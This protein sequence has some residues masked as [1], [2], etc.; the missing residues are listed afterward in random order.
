MAQSMARAAWSATVAAA[1]AQAMARDATVA[2]EAARAKAH[3][4]GARGMG[5]TNATVQA[6]HDA[7]DRWSAASQRARRRQRRSKRRGARA[8]KH[9]A[10]VC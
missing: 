5:A 7:T 2:A 3:E 9:D 10:A 8:E 6:K 1:A 4:N